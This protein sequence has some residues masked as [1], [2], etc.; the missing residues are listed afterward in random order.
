MT[1]FLLLMLEVEPPYVNYVGMETRKIL[2]TPAL[3]DFI[4]YMVDKES[5]VLRLREGIRGTGQ[6]SPYSV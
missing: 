2:L 3:K 1:P 5:R 6:Y 4:T